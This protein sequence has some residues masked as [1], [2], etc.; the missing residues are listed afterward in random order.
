MHALSNWSWQT[1]T[2]AASDIGYGHR[3]LSSGEK[4]RMVIAC[5]VYSGTNTAAAM[6]E[7]FIL[8]SMPPSTGATGE[9]NLAATGGV[10][11]IQGTAALDSATSLVLAQTLI[12]TVDTRA[13]GTWLILPPQSI[14]LFVPSI[15]NLNGTV[16][17]SLVSAEIGD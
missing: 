11:I 13:G 17:C 15:V 3:I 8:P 5:S 1:H 9:Y 10:K 12:P 14:L 6:S 16:V 2:L 7:L 4:P